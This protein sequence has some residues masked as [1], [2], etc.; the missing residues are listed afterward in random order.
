M[1]SWGRVSLISIKSCRVFTKA[2]F[3]PEGVLRVSSCV[4]TDAPVFLKIS[5]HSK[6]VPAF[7]SEVMISWKFDIIS[8]A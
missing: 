6:I 3:T 1:Q 5:V 2:G 8:V 7:G 4:H